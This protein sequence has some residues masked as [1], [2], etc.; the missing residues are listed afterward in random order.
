MVLILEPIDK[1]LL[2]DL[3]MQKKVIQELLE[4][5]GKCNALSKV[6]KFLWHECLPTDIRH[7]AKI[8]REK[9]SEWAEKQTITEASSL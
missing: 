8:F 5:A 3:R 6:T 1:T 7:N 9:L 2:S 4:L